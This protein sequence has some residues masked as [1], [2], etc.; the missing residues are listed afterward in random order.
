MSYVVVK[1]LL[2]TRV[3][4]L[5]Y[6]YNFCECIRSDREGGISPLKRKT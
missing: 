3:T 5:Y 6:V 4:W 1:T 2:T